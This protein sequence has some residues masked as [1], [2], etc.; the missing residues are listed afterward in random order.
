MKITLK[1]TTNGKATEHT[2]NLGEIISVGRSS[3]CELQVDDEKMSG[4]HC[5]LFLKIDRLEITDL[6]SKNGTYLNGIR[7]ETSEVFIGD[8]IRI[9]DTI[10]RLEE[11]N[12][13]SEALNILTFPGPQKDRISYELKADFTGARA[14]S[15]LA[16]KRVSVTPK[17]N[18]DASMIREMELRKKAHSK[19]KVP[20]D[21]IKKKFKIRGFIG[22]LL[23]FILLVVMIGISQNYD[24]HIPLQ[25][26]AAMTVLAGIAITIY[27]LFNLKMTKFTFGDRL[28]GIKE[29]YEKQ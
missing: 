23:D 4:R 28:S 5:R 2:M 7:V 9:G 13:D 1:F 19:L 22:M 25:K 17:V 11:K 8:E 15:Q 21:A 16:N 10:V 29:L 27:I 18:Y 3:K 12:V 26:P 6:D 14:Q 24:K 20:K